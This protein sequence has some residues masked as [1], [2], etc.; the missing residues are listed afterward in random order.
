MVKK[1]KNQGLCNEVYKIKKEEKDFI[2]RVFKKTH[3]VNINRKQEFKIQKKAYNKGIA[4]KPV[5]LSDK[6]MTCHF[7]KGV[8]K[9]KLS[10]K[11]IKTLAKSLQRLHKIKFNQKTNF[12]ENE[13]KSYKTLLKDEKSKK[14]I[15]KSLK[16]LRKNNK[17][18]DL[19]LCHNDLNKENI[20]FDNKAYF[21]DW[22]FASINNRF[23]DLATLCIK[24]NFSKEEEKILLSSYFPFIK[25]KYYRTLKNYK[26]ICKNFWKL[27]F[28][29][30]F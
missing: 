4:S 8:H 14:I 12:L 16:K 7:L 9:N 2:L 19:V 23:F 30:N 5:Y 20:I 25:E 1:L 11:D 29:T 6:F 3:S 28:K 10:K 26:V 15:K 27:W 17:K 18:K 24:Y 13:F 22:E 21:I